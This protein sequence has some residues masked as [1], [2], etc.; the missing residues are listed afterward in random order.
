MSNKQIKN[1]KRRLYYKKNREKILAGIKEYRVNNR[2]KVN[3]ERRLWYER[4]K[5]KE[6][7]YQK[8]YRKRN[9]D[10]LGE[11]KQ[12]IEYKEMIRRN[13]K[14]SVAKRRKKK[15]SV[16]VEHSVESESYKEIEITDPITGKK[17]TQKVKVTRYKPKTIAPTSIDEEDANE[18]INKINNSVN[19]TPIIDID[20]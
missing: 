13:N 10:K 7:L 14:K 20:A 15:G 2:E 11:K 17:I 3:K 1:Q 4:N 5:E 18:V 8:N 9:K 6:L 16:K 12:T 19:C